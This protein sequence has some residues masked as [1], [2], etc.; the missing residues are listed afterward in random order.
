VISRT[1]AKYVD[2]LASDRGLLAFF[3][4]FVV[5]FLLQIVAMIPVLPLLA[6]AV[7]TEG[8]AGK[9]AAAAFLTAFAAARVFLIALPCAR[10]AE[11]KG[12]GSRLAWGAGGLVFGQWMLALAASLPP[13]SARAPRAS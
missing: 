3:K 4:W 1:Y 5:G 8:D 10:A 13:R 6:Y 11:R 12:L 7:L 9:A 2:R